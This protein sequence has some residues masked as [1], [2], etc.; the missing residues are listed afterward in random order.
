[1]SSQK[2]V[3]NHVKGNHI[4]PL[5]NKILV[6]DMSFG[7]IKTKSGIILIN[8]D[9]T[10]RG[11]HPRWAQIYAVG[12]KVKDVHPLQWV[13]V[14]HGRWTRGVEFEVEDTAEIF[15]VREV[16]ESS[17]LLVAD[18]KPD[19]SRFSFPGKPDAI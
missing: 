15:T 3:I 2:P 14:D 12:D 11:I 7:D 17:I 16:E 8:D 5:K 19:F 13:L 10:S 18:E 4:Q 9:A 1:M 6:R